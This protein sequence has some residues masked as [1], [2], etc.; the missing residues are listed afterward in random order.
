MTIYP[1]KTPEALKALQQEYGI[2]ESHLASVRA[3]G[4]SISVPDLVTAFYGWLANTSAFRV[5]FN[6]PVALERVK[7][8]Q[9]LYWEQFFEAR[10]DDAFVERR[11]AVGRVHARIGLEAEPYFAAMNFCVGWLLE[12]VG[13]LELSPEEERLTFDGIRRLAYLDQALVIAALTRAHLGIM[14]EQQ[15]A[16]YE[17]G[18]PVVRLWDEIVLAPLVG[19]ITTERS[20][21]LLETLLDQIVAHEARVALVD[22]TGVP[23]MDTNVAGAMVKIVKAAQ[24]LG[25]RAILTG[26]KPE[27]ARTMIRLGVDLSMVRSFGS[28]KAGL[29]AA[30]SIVQEPPKVDNR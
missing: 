25:C 18:S 29:R 17:L 15:Q 20:D 10:I 22:V 14:E 5:Y 28:L 4:A 2:N 8:Q 12:R 16:I 7:A 13:E 6:D 21:V 9:T 26:I 1:V 24:M 30:L 11:A 27:A 19:T 23:V 3:A